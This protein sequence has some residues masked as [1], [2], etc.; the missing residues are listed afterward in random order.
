MEE[1]RRAGGV[2]CCV[3]VFV[4]VYVGWR[5]L[6]SQHVIPAGVTG[7]L[8]AARA[9]AW[10]NIFLFLPASSSAFR[11]SDCAW[12]CAHLHVVMSNYGSDIDDW[13]CFLKRKDLSHPE[14]WKTLDEPVTVACVCVCICARALCIWLLHSRGLLTCKTGSVT[15]LRRSPAPS[16]FQR[17]RP[18]AV[19]VLYSS[20]LSLSQPRRPIAVCSRSLDAH[21]LCP[22]RP[23]VERQPAPC[24]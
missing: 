17:C 14:A 7:Y 5:E 24:L 18:I 1:G 22:V 4:C 12:F 6:S 2:V 10:R 9:A 21:A 23:G 20:A 19:C 15:W 8:R 16:L 3:C 11:R 13:E